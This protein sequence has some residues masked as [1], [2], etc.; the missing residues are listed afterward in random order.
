MYNIIL[1]LSQLYC[2]HLI[3]LEQDSLYFSL[4]L[5][6]PL[7]LVYVSR[8]THNMVNPFMAV[9]RFFQYNGHSNK[10]AP[11]LIVFQHEFLCPRGP[12]SGIT[13]YFVH[14]CRFGM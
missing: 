7:L 13:G 11:L 1:K 4:V 6:E 14:Y 12:I 3:S 9:A 2:N 8:W 10:L 5:S